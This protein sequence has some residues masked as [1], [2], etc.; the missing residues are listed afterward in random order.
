MDPWL[1]TS[2]KISLKSDLKKI[3]GAG[4]AMGCGSYLFLNRNFQADRRVIE[5]MIKYYADS[6]FKYQILLFPEGTDRGERAAR[7][8]NEYAENN[9]LPKYDY[10]LHPRTVGFNYLLEL[11]RKNNYIDYVYD[12]TVAYAHSI[13]SSELELCKTGNFPESVHFDTGNFPESVHFDVCKYPISDV[14][15][16]EPDNEVAKERGSAWLLDLWKAKEQRLKKFY[17]EKDPEKRKL[18]PSGEQFVWPV[19][20][21]GIGYIVAFAIWILTSVMWVYFA[22]NSLL[23]DIYIVAA[24]SFYFRYLYRR[25]RLLLLICVQVSWWRGVPPNGVVLRQTVLL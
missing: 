25:C 24:V 16:E 18:K 3:P 12:V 8:S 2:E 9:G 21:R 23:V 22:L 11:M 4:W 7:I 19:E 15:G 14:I 10:V 6:Q 17:S 13:I 5:Q 1:L 20:T